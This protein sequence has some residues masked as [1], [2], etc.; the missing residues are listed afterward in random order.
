MKWFSLLFLLMLVNVGNIHGQNESYS[1][2]FDPK[3]YT[4]QTFSFEGKDYKVRAFENIVYVANP[5]DTAYQK[6]N[7]YVPEE[8]F[9]EGTLNGY[10]MDNAPVLFPNGIGGYMPSGP[11]SLSGNSGRNIF[12]MPGGGRPPRRMPQQ[13]PNA[14]TKKGSII[15]YALAHGYVVASAGARGRSLQ[16]ADSVYTGKA[17]AGL[18]DLK[19]AVRYLRHNAAIIPGDQERIIPNGTSAGGA[20]ST[21]LGATGN[22]PDYTPYLEEIGAADAPDDIFAVSAYCPITDLDHADCAYEWQFNGINTYQSFML[23]MIESIAPGT[24]NMR[25]LS[26]AQQLT[27]DQLKPLFPLYL[28]SLNLKDQDGI[29]LTLDESGNGNF[30]DYV[31]SFV[32]SSAQRQ[33]DN[34]KDLSKVSWLKVENNRAVSLNFTEYIE[35][36]KRM[37]TP[38][39]FDAFDLSAPENHLFGTGSI[40]S[41]HFTEF[42]YNN[43]PEKHTLASQDIINMMNPLHYIGLSNTSTS[44][45]WHIRYGTIDNNTSLA[46]EVILATTLM[47]KGYNVD[48]ELAW[49]R[50]HRGDYDLDELFGWIDNIVKKEN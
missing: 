19:A 1:L 5:V 20:M 38:P 14:D 23:D 41:Q 22:N 7:I 47:N 50:P 27:S 45:N 15:H 11:L 6:M 48:F 18:V 32:L 46:I 2:E 12:G 49:D 17:P 24:Q 37:K 28:N 30:K 35:N 43:A 25:S 13:T 4:L 31:I 9:H 16:N 40:T 10:N 3:N 39:A 26:A 36:M 44:R 33:L 42:S 21:L 8:Y 34:G 29:L